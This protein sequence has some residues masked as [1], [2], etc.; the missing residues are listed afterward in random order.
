V[1]N[2]S[3]TA[4]KYDGEKFTILERG[5]CD[6]MGNLATKLPKNS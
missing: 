5:T 4:V 1:P 3:V 6:Y 2:A